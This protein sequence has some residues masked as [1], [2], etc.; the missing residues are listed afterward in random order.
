MSKIL[1]NKEQ[2]PDPVDSVLKDKKLFNLSIDNDRAQEI[3]QRHSL[4]EK[5]VENALIPFK[6]KATAKCLKLVAG[7]YKV[8]IKNNSPHADDDKSENDEFNNSTSQNRK[9]PSIK[10]FFISLRNL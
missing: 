3:T 1:S 4:I 8:K 6:D 10:V 7:K 5:V 9:L 2:K